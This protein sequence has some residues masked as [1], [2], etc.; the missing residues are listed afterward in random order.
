MNLHSIASQYTAAVNPFT[1]AQWYQSTGSTTNA[2]GSRT[3]AFAAPQTIPVQNQALTASD[4][5]HLDALNIQTVTRKVWASGSLQ[6]VN[7]ATQ[8]GG[9]KLVF[10][11]RTWLVTIVFE[12]WD[13]DGPWCSV[14]LTQQVGS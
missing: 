2:D 5:R 9:D 3:P 4:L 11:G 13:A 7:R 12:T 8:Q 10:G 6:G 14:G 1:I